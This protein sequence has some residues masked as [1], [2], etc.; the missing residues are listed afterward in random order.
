MDNTDQGMVWGDGDWDW[1]WDS[2][3]EWGRSEGVALALW[4]INMLQRLERR[5]Q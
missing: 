1:D 3:W 5:R 4:V 2:D